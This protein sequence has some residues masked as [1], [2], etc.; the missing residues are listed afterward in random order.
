MFI[1]NPRILYVDNKDNF[2]MMELMLSLAEPD[3]ELIGAASAEE[4]AYFMGKEKFDLY[5]L[6]YLLPGTSGIEL[7]RQIRHADPHTPILFYSG[8]AR[9]ADRGAAMAE[10]AT[11]YLIK[12]NDLDKVIGIIIGLVNKNSS[13]PEPARRREVYQGIF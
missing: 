12:P 11:E 10:G 13:F 1:S 3:Y 4:A 8:M 2:Q 7:C 9:P 5:V 6:E